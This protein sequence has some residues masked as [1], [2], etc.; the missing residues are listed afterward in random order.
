MHFNR[1]KAF[2]AFAEWFPI[3][4]LMLSN[5]QFYATTLNTVESALTDSFPHLTMFIKISICNHLNHLIKT[6]FG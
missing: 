4:M 2:K 5:L 1:L 3:K 6:K